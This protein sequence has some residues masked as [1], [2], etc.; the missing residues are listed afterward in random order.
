MALN[1]EFSLDYAIQQDG[2]NHIKSKAI[3]WE[4]C[5]FELPSGKR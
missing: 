5:Y 4:K 2:H 3:N 1:L